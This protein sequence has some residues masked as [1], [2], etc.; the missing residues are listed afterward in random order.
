MRY[1]VVRCTLNF[2]IFLILILSATVGGAATMRIAYVAPDPT[3]T[4]LWAAKDF[5]FF[6]KN[7]FAAELIS[8]NSSSQALASLLG[9]EVDVVVGG[10][11]SGIA[12]H[13][14]G[15]SDLQFFAGLV[16]RLVFSI[17]AKPSFSSVAE[18]RGKRVGVTRFGGSLDFAVR[19]ALTKAG[20]DPKR[21]VLM[22]QI[23]QLSDIVRALAAGSI[24]AGG[25]SYP[26]AQSARQLGFKELLD[27]GKLELK[28][29]QGAMLAKKR[30]LESNPDN[31]K[32]FVT[33]LVEGIHFIKTHPEQAKA[34]IRKY[35]KVTDDD[36]LAKSFSLYVDN[37]LPRLPE[38][39][40]ERLKLV[41]DNMAP[42][43]KKALEAKG[44]QFIYDRYIREVE[45][46]GIL[47]KLYG[48]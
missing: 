48:D 35:T 37:Y 13:L 24:D 20:I 43:N 9:G 33:A 11:A 38:I 32:K 23:G 18:L 10:A 34:I 3:Y 4:S 5:G 36:A 22:I 30:F 26:I 39:T 7:D 46:S 12:A 16:D 17:F 47:K 14:G 8:I 19:F 28:Y 44:S 29:Q 40:E 6:K 1:R 41:L 15:A 27:I 25:L 45:A 2:L 42:T 21:D 31:I